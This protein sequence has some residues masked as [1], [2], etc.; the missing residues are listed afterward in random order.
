MFSETQIIVLIVIALLGHT[1]ALFWY[2]SDKRNARLCRKKIYN[3]PYKEG[4]IRREVLN[5]VHTP[6][7][8]IMLAG[9]LYFGFFTNQ[10]TFSFFVSFLG[11]F[12]WAEIWHYTSHRLLHLRKLHWIHREHHKS[13]VNSPFSAISFSFSEKLVFNLG[14]MGLMVLVDIFV[15]VNFYGVAAW[16]IGYLLI[17]SF[18]HANFEIKSAGY[19]K[20]VGKFLT[21]TT[22]HS[23]HHSRY[24]NNYGLG[25]RFL[26]RL[27]GTEWR[28]YEELYQRLTEAK[29]PLN[30]INEKLPPY[31]NS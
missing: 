11:T 28:D 26:D 20:F 30:D 23:L 13:R 29:S 21:S 25:T 19:L 1:M 31:E 8:A 16:Y 5:S 12:V 9:C 22:Y 6:I 27:L 17:N 4:Q 2:F 10:S 24:I 3:I 15:S 18:S 14:I 7:H